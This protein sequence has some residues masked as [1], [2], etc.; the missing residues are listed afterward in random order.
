MQQIIE[1]QSSVSMQRGRGVMSSYLAIGMV[2]VRVVLS[3]TEVL[4][5]SCSSITCIMIDQ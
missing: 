1:W 4:L 2:L 5:G 3:G